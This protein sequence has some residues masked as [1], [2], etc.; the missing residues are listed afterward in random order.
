MRVPDP[1]SRGDRKSGFSP[2]IHASH[3]I[4]HMRIAKIGQRL[5]GNVAA[6]P[7][8]A[9]HNNVV[10]QFRA[11]LSVPRLQLTKVDVHVGAG[12][13]ESAHLRVRSLWHS[14]TVP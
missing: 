4:V 11:K 7:R 14:S 9:V 13:P 1:P 10:I 2:S 3:D 12:N 8:L 5:C 6:V